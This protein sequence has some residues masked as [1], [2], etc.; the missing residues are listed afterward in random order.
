ML[1]EQA[2]IT[3]QGIRTGKALQLTTFLAKASTG[4]LEKQMLKR[5]LKQIP[6]PALTN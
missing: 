3:R 1:V 5:N 6:P 4:F 2:G